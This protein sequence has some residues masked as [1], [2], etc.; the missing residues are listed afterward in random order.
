V[1]LQ[2]GTYKLG[3]D[4][5]TLSVHTG[6][7][8]AAAKAGHDLVIHVTAWEA[9]LR[10]GDSPADTSVELEA[11]ATSLHVREGTGGMQSLGDDDKANIR[12]TIHDDVLKGHAIA[13]RSTAVTGDDGRLSVQGELTLVGTTRPLAFDLVVGDDG[14]L[15]GTAV[16]KQS[17]WGMKP[18]S[19]LFGAL[20]VADDV[21]VQIDAGLPQSL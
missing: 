18:Y 9:T 6:R 21:R 1:S 8:G 2:A 12:T 3:P 14:R 13:F 20:K 15:T 11:D 4:H 7:T 5:G 10:V 16:L 19:A 17:D